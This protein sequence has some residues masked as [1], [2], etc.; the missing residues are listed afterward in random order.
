MPK[1]V[2]FKLSELAASVASGIQIT[3]SELTSKA[4]VAALALAGK[5]VQSVGGMCCD[6]SGNIYVSDTEQ[7]IIL[8]INESGK[9][10]T[11]AGVAGS[12]GNNSALQNVAAATARFN[13]PKGLACDNTGN[14]YVADY[15]NNQIRKIDGQGRVSVLAGNGATTSGLVDSTSDPLQS[16]FSHPSDVAVDASG[17]VYVADTDNNAIR[18]IY[19]GQV[20]TIAGGTGTTDAWNVR[21]SKYIPFCSAPTT[22]DV[23]QRGDLFIGDSGH[24]RIKKIT[25]NGWVYNFSGSGVSGHSIGTAGVTA[26]TAQA[27]TCTYTAVQYLRVDRYGYVYAI[28]RDTSTGYSRLV[29]ITPNGVPSIAVDFHTATTNYAGIAGVAVSPAGKVFVSISLASEAV[30]SSSS[31]SVDSSSSSSSSSSVDSSS[32]SSSSPGA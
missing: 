32:S 1:I 28:D 5:S 15:G 31:S 16:R 13:Q 24:Y 2:L 20:L 23:N 30:S 29:K 8:K 11:I 22:I 4:V 12:A 3:E 7:S 27:Y 10:N 6:K 25:P 14:I 17:N 26:A 9:I 18:K 19:R 21:A